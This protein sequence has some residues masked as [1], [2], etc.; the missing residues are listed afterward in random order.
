MNSIITIIVLL[1]GIFHSEIEV[2][3]FWKL[4]STVSNRYHTI[5]EITRTDD[6][7]QRYYPTEKEYEL[8]C[9][10]VMSESGCQTFDTKVAVAETI[11]NRYFL[12]YGTIEE[13]INQP[14]QYSTSDNGVPN[15]E[16]I[17][18]V[19]QAISYATYD[20]DMIYFR[21]YYYH[22]FAKDYKK[23]DDLYFSKK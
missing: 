18:A 12:G 8:L 10:V 6:V 22:S 5:L 20:T 19:D 11:L 14:Y 21:Q 9:R 16:C 13:I 15:E 1:L 7:T 4:P 2:N 17:L 3:S 23:L